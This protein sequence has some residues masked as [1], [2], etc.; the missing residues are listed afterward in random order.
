MVE[1]QFNSNYDNPPVF[2]SVEYNE[3]DQTFTFEL[4]INMQ[5]MIM[6]MME[7]V[8]M[9]LIQDESVED[10]EYFITEILVK[11]YKDP[12]DWLDMSAF[13]RLIP[14]AVDETVDISWGHKFV[15]NL[16]ISKFLREEMMVK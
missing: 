5:A 16:K 7:A 14:E 11:K 15:L 1:Y 2:Y 6:D 13:Y 3:D 12:N 10:I 4:E 8:V 9:I